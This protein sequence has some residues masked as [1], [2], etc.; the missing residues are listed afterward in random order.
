MKR[1][2]EGA[3]DHWSGHMTSGNVFGMSFAL[4]QLANQVGLTRVLGNAWET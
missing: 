1:L 2:V 4:K 3:F